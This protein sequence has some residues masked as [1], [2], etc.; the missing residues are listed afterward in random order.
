MSRVPGSLMPMPF[1]PFPLMTFRSAPVAPPTVA[2]VSPS[3]M[4]IPSVRL[5][6]AAVPASFKPITLP[7]T[8]LSLPA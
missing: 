3:S 2:F 8:W 1:A 4:M 6:R 7:R 5:G